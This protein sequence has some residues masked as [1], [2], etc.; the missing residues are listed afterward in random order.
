M[1]SSIRTSRRQN[2][3]NS[4]IY[5]RLLLKKMSEKLESKKAIIMTS[6]LSQKGYGACLT[7]F[8]ERLGLRGQE[9]LVT[10]VNVSM[11]PFISPSNFEQVLADAFREVA[12]EEVKVS[13]ASNK[14][15]SALRAFVLQGSAPVSLVHMACFGTAS[16][17]QQCILKGELLDAGLRAYLDAKRADSTSTYLVC[18]LE[19]E[20]LSTIIRRESFKGMIL[21][22]TSASALLRKRRSN[23]RVIKD[24]P[25][26]SR[27]F[28]MAYP[29]RMPFYLYGTRQGMHIDHI[30]VQAPNAQLSV[31]EV[32]YE[33]IEGSESV[34]AEGLESGF[35]AVADALPE[36]LMQPFTSDRLE[37][38]FYPG[39]K[40]DVTTYPDEGAA[41][42][43][44]H[45]LCDNLGEP[46][47]RAR[48][49]LGDNT[50]VDEHMI[51]LDPVAAMPQT[52]KNSMPVPGASQR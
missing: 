45:D 40:L 7:K 25:L 48:I 9:D 44:G 5:D 27:H 26:S 39:A 30:L 35:I 34:I 33:L 20:G 19:R 32:T 37:S 2:A 10:L 28:D 12:E 16:Q 14:S 49:T 15:L 11:S 52:S 1:G 50:F 13:V 42:S 43:Q 38:F 23:I 24:Q 3:L 51:N 22:L 29:S 41:Q 6:K 46:I 18:T 47:A 4:C 36:H 31:G 17:R 8:K 21:K